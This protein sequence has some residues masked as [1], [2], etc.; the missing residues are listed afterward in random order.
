VHLAAYRVKVYYVLFKYLNGCLDLAICAHSLFLLYVS[1][2][3][4]LSLFECSSNVTST[5]IV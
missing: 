4:T 5:Y 2:K 1:S 3:F